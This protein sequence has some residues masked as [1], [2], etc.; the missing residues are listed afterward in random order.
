[1]GALDYRN[2]AALAE[3]RAKNQFWVDGNKEVA[4][5]FADASFA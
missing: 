5:S 4:F 2:R 3:S 1:M